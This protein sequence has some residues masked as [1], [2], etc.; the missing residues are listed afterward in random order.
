MILATAPGGT[1]VLWTAFRL[2]AFP[3]CHCW[4]MPVLLKRQRIWPKE[5]VSGVAEMTTCTTTL[6]PHHLP[7]DILLGKAN[8]KIADLKEDIRRL[9]RTQC[10]GILLLAP[11]TPVRKE[12]W[13]EVVVRG[14]RKTMGNDPPPRLLDTSNCFEAQVSANPRAYLTDDPVSGH[15]ASRYQNTAPM[16]PAN[17]PPL[18][19]DSAG[20]VASTAPSRPPDRPSTQSS[21]SKKPSSYMPQATLARIRRRIAVVLQTHHLRV[22]LFHRARG[23]RW[24][25]AARIRGPSVRLGLLPFLGMGIS[26][27][28]W[29]P[30]LLMP[31]KPGTHPHLPQQC[32]DRPAQSR[33]PRTSREP[34]ARTQEQPC[35]WSGPPWSATWQYITARPSAILA[36]ALRT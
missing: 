32:T 14:R 29:D 6:L 35:W 17:F 8:K 34:E 7:P 27:V 18:V 36:P 23:P 19:P 10:S 33:A 21:T 31:L 30:A 9:S 2:E 13:T 11:T 20:M 5:I 12:S 4:L 15:T 26:R 3:M 25:P 22:R 28:M 16:N 1:R 24:V